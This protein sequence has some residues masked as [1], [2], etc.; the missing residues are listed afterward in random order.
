M[1][2]LAVNI[3]QYKGIAKFYIDRLIF[4]LLRSAQAK[5]IRSRLL[6]KKLV[7]GIFFKYDVRKV[8]SVNLL[9]FSTA[10]GIN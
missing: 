9:T 4:Y 8:L 5:K 2:E 3:K 6:L 7:F 10:T 1:F